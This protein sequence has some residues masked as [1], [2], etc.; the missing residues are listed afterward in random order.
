M[1]TKY[2]VHCTATT[3]KTFKHGNWRGEPRWESN[4]VDALLTE[5]KIVHST[6]NI[7][8]S[9]EPRPHNLYDMNTSWMDESIQISYGVPH[10][11]HTGVYPPEATP[12]YRVVQY[13]DGPTASTKDK[14]LRFD[15]QLPGSIVATC[16]FKSGAYLKKLQNVLGSENVEWT[17]G[18]TVPQVYKEH[19]AFTQPNML[20]AYRNFCKY[21]NSRPTEMQKL[22]GIVA[23][24]LKNNPE[25]KLVMLVQ[26]HTQEEAVRINKDCREF[27][28]SFGFTKQLSPYKDRVEVHTAIDW[29]DVL[30][31]MSKTKLV[32]SPA[33]P[34]GGPPF[35]AASYGV[36]IVLE[37]RTNP[38]IETNGRLMFPEVLTSAPGLTNQFFNQIQKLQTDSAFHHKHGNAY[39]SFV[40]GHATYSAYVRKL[41]EISKKRGWSV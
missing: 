19:D 7:W 33:E 36:P 30:D 22:F 10:E 21:A 35:E 27:F 18:P 39:R 25:M 17:Y 31:I 28:F 38:F 13:Q 16:S 3:A 2:L 32:I 24:N 12:K 9:P 1:S 6:T 11:I 8:Q 29:I 15:K 37:H 5:G 26:P 23:D 20:W 40:D 41:E 34:L 4:A 14:F